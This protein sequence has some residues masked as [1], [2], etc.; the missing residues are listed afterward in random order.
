MHDGTVDRIGMRFPS[1]SGLR[2]RL[3]WR[4]A[5]RFLVAAVYFFCSYWMDKYNLLRLF[6][7]RKHGNDKVGSGIVCLPCAGAARPA[8]LPAG[9]KTSKT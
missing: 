3:R 4:R 7:V 5:I 2:L 8:A 6:A 1:S 9:P